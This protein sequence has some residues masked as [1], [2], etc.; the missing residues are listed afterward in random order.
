MNM[1]TSYHGQDAKNFSQTCS[2]Q[3]KSR[4]LSM[5]YHGQRARLSGRHDQGKN[6]AQC[7]MIKMPKTQNRGIYIPQK[8][9]GELLGVGER[10]IESGRR[11]GG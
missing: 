1:S 7:T 2:K 4:K 11:E 9:R 10:T 8:R 3:N 5:L 6:S